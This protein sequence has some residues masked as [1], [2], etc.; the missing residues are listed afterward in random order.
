MI[1]R[2]APKEFNRSES[3]IKYSVRIWGITLFFERAM[4]MVSDI[5]TSISFT[6]CLV[7]LKIVDSI[8][9]TRLPTR[10]IIPI[11]DY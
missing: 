9:L 5:A 6:T 8:T 1:F 11:L 10:P 3:T 4:P 2:N 7:L